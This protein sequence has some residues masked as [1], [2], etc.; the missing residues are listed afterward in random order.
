MIRALSL[1][2]SLAFTSYAVAGHHTETTVSLPTKPSFFA[3]TFPGTYQSGK[4][5]SDVVAWGEDFAEVV[6]ADETPYRMTTWTPFYMSQSALPDIAKFDTLFFGLWPSLSDFGRGWAG[7]FKNGA[8]VQAAIDKIIVPTND[9]TMM[10]GY[11]LITKGPGKPNNGLIRIKGCAL[12]EGKTPNDAYPVAMAIA[13]MADKGGAGF[14]TSF[15]LLPGPGSAPSQDNHVYLVEA[16]NS[17]EDYGVGYDNLVGATMQTINAKSAA[18][19]DCDAP[20]L[21][22]SN[23]VYWP[24]E[25]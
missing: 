2:L 8:K 21:Y 4:D 1:V 23:A 15:M 25:S 5:L 10:V 13:E 17:V 3:Q 19:M 16:F 9:R 14:R 7:Y 22:L 6:E 18:V 24:S 11:S 12:L 20:R